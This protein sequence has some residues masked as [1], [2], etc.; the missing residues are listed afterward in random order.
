MDPL[1]FT[2]LLVQGSAVFCNENIVLHN[3]RRTH[4]NLWSHM[5]DVTFCYTY[6]PWKAIVVLE[7]HPNQGCHALFKCWFFSCKR[8]LVLKCFQ[9]SQAFRKNNVRVYAYYL[10]FKFWHDFKRWSSCPDFWCRKWLKILHSSK[11]SVFDK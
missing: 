3:V 7:I 1:G 6:K 9:Q 5:P 10:K 8:M 4:G 11:Y 2:S